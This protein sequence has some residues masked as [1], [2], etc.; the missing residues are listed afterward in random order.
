MSW[1]RNLGSFTSFM[2]RKSWIRQHLG[3]INH[4]NRMCVL[5]LRIDFKRNFHDTYQ[6]V[7]ILIRKREFEISS[8]HQ[9]GFDSPHAVIVME[10]GRELL[11]AE[12]VR[13]HNLD[14][15]WLGVEE[16]ERIQGN[17][18]DECIVRHHHGDCSKQ[19]LHRQEKEE[20]LAQ[21]WKKNTTFCCFRWCKSLTQKKYL[22]ITIYSQW[23]MDYVMTCKPSSYLEALIVLH[24][25]DSS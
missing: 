16:A 22:A 4:W 5:S 3:T 2:E 9:D 20:K 10:L 13:H 14:W 1:D 15:Q 21:V 12:P 19:H 17:L 7:F 8:S 25:Q 18:S 23:F 24:I 6:D 11:R